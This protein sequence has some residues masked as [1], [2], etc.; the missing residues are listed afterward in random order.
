MFPGNQ[1]AARQDVP[2]A[3][4]LQGWKHR[5]VDHSQGIKAGQSLGVE[6]EPQRQK[7]VIRRLM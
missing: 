5:T 3:I 6:R 2:G 7:M 4:A 1:E